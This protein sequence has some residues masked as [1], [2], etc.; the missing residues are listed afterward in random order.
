MGFITEVLNK[1]NYVDRLCGTRVNYSVLKFSSVS[2]AK[3]L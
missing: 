1:E 2:D 3:A